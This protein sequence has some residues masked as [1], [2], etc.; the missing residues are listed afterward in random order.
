M[1]A[2][3]YIALFACAG[4]LLLALSALR[5]TGTSPLALPLALFS[6][7]LAAW[8]FAGAAKELSEHQRWVWDWLDATATPLTAPLGVWF[9]LTFVGERKRLRWPHRATWAYFG[10]IAAVGCAS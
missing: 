8:N 1:T 6:A 4:Q 7:N 3:G 5:R 9:V 10:A 2:S